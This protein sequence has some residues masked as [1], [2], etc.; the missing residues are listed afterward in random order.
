MTPSK[1]QE[2]VGGKWRSPASWIESPP[3]CEQEWKQEGCRSSMALTLTLVREML[4]TASDFLFRIFT[5]WNRR[6][7]DWRIFLGSAERYPWM[8]TGS[9]LSTQSMGFEKKG[10]SKFLISCQLENPEFESICFIHWWLNRKKIIITW[11]LWKDLCS[12]HWQRNKD[13]R[14]TFLS[15]KALA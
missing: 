3:Q 5:G 10:S 6:Q 4:P 15:R 7:V 8:S 14:I 12:C 11:A 13:L 1:L 2:I 9:S